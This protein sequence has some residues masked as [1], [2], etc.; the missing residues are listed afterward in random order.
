MLARSATRARAV[1][2]IRA[3]AK[4]WR[5]T[6]GDGRRAQQEFLEVERQV[7]ELRQNHAQERDP[8]VSENTELGVRPGME[9]VERTWKRVA[10]AFGIA[11]LLFVAVPSF[12]AAKEDME[13]Y[14]ESQTRR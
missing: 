5:Y 7:A 8:F 13:V 14:R 12:F 4:R 3:V 6:E 1:T 2:A 9:Q 10:A 11:V